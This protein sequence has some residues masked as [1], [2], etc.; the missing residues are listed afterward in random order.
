[1]L[2]LWI[3]S[4]GLKYGYDPDAPQSSD[5]ILSHIPIPIC[6]ADRVIVEDKQ[7]WLVKD[8]YID[9]LPLLW[10]EYRNIGGPCELRLMFDGVSFTKIIDKGN[11]HDIDRAQQ[12]LE[13]VKKD[14]D[15]GK[16]IHVEHGREYS[17]EEIAVAFNTSVERIRQIEA[18]ALRKLRHPS[19]S[20]FLQEFRRKIVS[21]LTAK[22]R[23]KPKL[24]L[25]QSE[26]YISNYWPKVL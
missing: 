10:E 12:I 2:S 25:E 5:V 19:R 11:K 23:V 14:M 21:Q 24:T 3:L 17:K 13:M 16:H 1:M 4:S 6:M 8:N 15:F 9:N 22:G 18:K 20:K 7:N 26:E